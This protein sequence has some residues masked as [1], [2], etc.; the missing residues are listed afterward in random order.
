MA[1]GTRE[2][3]RDVPGVPGERRVLGHALEFRR[4]PLRL[5]QRAREHGDVVRVRLG[6]IHVYVL[7]SPEAIRQA[8]V[9]QARKLEKG[10]DFGRTKRLMGNGLVMSAGE[11][12]HRQRRLMQPAFHR[13]EI[14]RYMDTMRDVAVPRIDAWPDGGTLAF[15][16]EIRSITLTVLTRTLLSSDVGSE[17]ISEIDRLLRVLLAEL[18]PKGIIA[19][20]PVLARVPTRSNRRFNA[21]N[22]RL[23]VVLTDIIDGYRAVGADHGDLMSILLHA[24]D[25]ETGTGMTTRQLRDEATTL[26]IA[27][28]ETT[29]NTIAWACYLLTQHPQ[30]QERL[31]R[32]VDLV[33]AAGDAGY[34]TLARLPFT[35]AVITETLRLYSP[36]WILPRQATADV[37]LG[38]HLLPAGSRILFSPYALNRDPRLHRDPDRFDPDRWA[39][40]YTPADMRASFFPFGQGIRHCIGEGFAWTE[41]MLLL[42]AIAARWQLRLADGAVVHPVVSS[43]LVTNELPII[44]TRRRDENRL[45]ARGNHSYVRDNEFDFLLYP[46]QNAVSPR[47]QEAAHAWPDFRL[48]SHERLK[49]RAHQA[50]RHGLA[51]P[52]GAERCLQCRSVRCAVARNRRILQELKDSAMSV[53]SIIG[54]SRR[55]GPGIHGRTGMLPRS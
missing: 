36:V 31:Q 53:W 33:L 38:G 32:E 3:A 37:E 39:A 5:L 45:A 34:E 17:T 2:V 18:L 40:D 49:L 44:V 47:S 27:G 42:S 30:V 28:S 46:G 15:D 54:L 1:V 6:P 52:D 55:T 43:T 10:I 13:A 25:D 14:A 50:R 12:H 8:L 22:R 20:I 9:S 24:R 19:N 4:D 23:G 48:R 41:A 21:A 29:G 11:Y 16:R 51:E 7:N 26:V 35:R